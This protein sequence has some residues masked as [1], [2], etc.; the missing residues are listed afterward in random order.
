MDVSLRGVRKTYRGGITALDRLDLDIPPGMFGVLG[1]NGAGKTTL[2]RILAGVS[3]PDRGSVRAG[4]W[5]LARPRDRR[6]FQERLGYL[7]RDLGLYPELT[8]R[9]FLDYAGSLKGLSSTRRRHRRVGEVLHLA[10]L[11]E[12]A[13]RPAGGYSGGMRRRLGLAQALLNDPAVLLLDEPTAGLDPEE[14]TRVRM[15]LTSLAGERT[16]VLATRDAADV[17]STCRRCAVLAGGR[18]I[19]SGDAAGLARAAD[20]LVW[21]VQTDRPLSAL[22]AAT[23]ASAV[24]LPD[25]TVYRVIS[26]A[27]PLPSARPLQP[28]LEDGYLALIRRQARAAA[29]ALPD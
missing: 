18:V 28:G 13:D 20:G 16:V 24:R 25:R 26:P 2:M 8:G 11:D 4:G 17:S 15:L 29:R 27:P 3:R 22:Q 6:Q 1:P 23:V 12:V 7:P 14:R 9:R 5:D 21:S 19:F 10:G